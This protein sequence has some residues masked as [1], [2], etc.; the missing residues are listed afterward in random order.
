MMRGLRFSASRG[1]KRL[2]T[3]VVTQVAPPGRRDSETAVL[4]EIYVPLLTP[5]LWHQA[6]RAPIQLAAR[7]LA[8]AAKR[9][10]LA[11]LAPEPVGGRLFSRFSEVRDAC[12]ENAL[13]RLCAA[14]PDAT[15]RRD[16]LEESTRIEYAVRRGRVSEH[17][18]RRLVELAPTEVRLMRD[19][20]RRPSGRNGRGP[21]RAALWTAE[22][23]AY[24][25]DDV[26]RYASSPTVGRTNIYAAFV[27]TYG[28]SAPDRLH[29]EVAS[30]RR[31]FEQQLASVAVDERLWLERSC[32]HRFAAAFGDYPGPAPERHE[33]ERAAEGVSSAVVLFGMLCVVGWLVAYAGIIYRGFAD[34]TFGVPL[35]ALFANL[36]WEFTYGFLLDPLGDYFHTSSIFGFL[37]DT[38]IAWQA[39]TYGAAQFPNSPLGRH[40]RPIFLTCLAIALP[41][42]YYGFLDLQDP[43][44]EYTGF[45]I[46]LMMSIL[47]I[48]MLEDRGTPA[49]QSMY[50]AVGKWLGTLFAWVATALTVTTSPERTWPTSWAQFTRESLRHRSYPLTPLINVMYGWT[51][52]L[53]AVYCVLLH[54]RLQ[55]AGISPWRRF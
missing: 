24:I 17:D 14:N 21:V 55:L 46:N 27:D 41:V 45:G 28:D 5:S 52:V 4:D 10:R 36:T 9:G 6:R 30:Y 43:D 18:L 2:L 51:F 40:F 39:W 11:A 49:G 33:G 32:A 7:Y 38:V 23:L 13:A 8:F 19:L 29:S 1:A 48:K 54:R 44:G 12:V 26:S 31:I 35:A 42:N 47:Y 3:R 34:Q 20:G 37:V 50:I 16:E 53:D 22:I 25:A 15:R